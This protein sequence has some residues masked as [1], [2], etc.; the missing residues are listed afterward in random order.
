MDPIFSNESGVLTESN[1]PKFKPTPLPTS[2]SPSYLVFYFGHLQVPTP[3]API[4]GSSFD[5]HLEEE[6]KKKK[7]RIE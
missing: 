4:E 7:E 1:E 3:C 6:E 2:V 5:A